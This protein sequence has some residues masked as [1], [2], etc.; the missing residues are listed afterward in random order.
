MSD[1]TGVSVNLSTA[2]FKNASSEEV[3]INGKDGSISNGHWAIFSG[4]PDIDTVRKAALLRL[5]KKDIYWDKPWKFVDKRKLM[6]DMDIKSFCSRLYDG[7]S[8]AVEDGF[9]LLSEEEVGCCING[10][11]PMNQI[12]RFHFEIV[13]QEMIKPYTAHINASYCFAFKRMGFQL[14]IPL[15]RTDPVLVV[16]EDGAWYKVHGCIMCLKQ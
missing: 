6:S 11:I 5:Q 9:I 1:I 15:E 8:Y 4:S 10:Y 2:L 3:I 13:Y 14:L 12:T 16:K 7:R